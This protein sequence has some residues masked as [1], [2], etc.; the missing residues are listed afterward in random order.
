MLFIQLKSG[1]W[2]PQSLGNIKGLGLLVCYII[3]VWIV[4]VCWLPHFQGS[5]GNGNTLMSVRFWR[6]SVLFLYE[7]LGA[8]RHQSV[9]QLTTQLRKYLIGNKIIFRSWRYVQFFTNKGSVPQFGELV[10]NILSLGLLRL[11]QWPIHHYLSLHARKRKTF[12]LSFKF[13]G[14]WQFALCG[15]TFQLTRK[16]FVMITIKRKPRTQFLWHTLREKPIAFGLVNPKALQAM[17]LVEE[18]QTIAIGKAGRTRHGKAIALY[19]FYFPNKRSDR[20]RSVER[21]DTLGHALHEIG[22]VTSIESFS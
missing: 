22:S 3:K 21:S 7:Q 15:F 9:N 6:F 13:H 11:F 4:T 18:R 12:W 17:V 2:L 5:L 14:Q 16:R 19:F 10:A 20:L 1:N 8:Y